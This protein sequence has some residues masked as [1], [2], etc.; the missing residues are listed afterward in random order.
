[1]WSYHNNLSIYLSTESN[2]KPLKTTSVHIQTTDDIVSEITN[3]WLPWLKTYALK[4]CNNH[5]ADAEDLYQETVLKVLSNKSKFRL[6]S[7]FKARTSTI[8]KN[9]FINWWRK[10]Q[11][12]P[13]YF[14]GDNTFH[15]EPSTLE[16]NAPGDLEIEQLFTYISSL[17]DQNRVPFE[18]ALQWFSYE[19]IEAELAI[20]L[21][22]VKSRIFFA[23]KELKKHIWLDRY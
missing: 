16:N 4:L 5:E 18:M 14:T 23:R 21:W 8:M 12:N 6:W 20:P 15:L 10:K 13:I 22:T 3:S 7:N 11:N 17:P 9:W 19:E 2:D 1:M